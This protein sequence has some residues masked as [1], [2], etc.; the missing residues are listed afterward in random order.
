MVANHSIPLSWFQRALI[1]AIGLL[2]IAT[3]VLI[4][5]A[6]AGSATSSPPPVWKFTDGPSVVHALDST[7]TFGVSP[8]RLSP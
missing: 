2:L 3:A 4:G 1:I 8:V 5:L 6:V 7:N